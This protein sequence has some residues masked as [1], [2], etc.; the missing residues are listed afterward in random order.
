MSASTMTT[1][2]RSGKSA[3][4]AGWICLAGG[5]IG[6]AQ[7]LYLLFVTPVVGEDRFSYPFTA[8][9][10]TIAQL[11]FAIQHLML[12][13]G[14]VALARSDWARRSRLAVVGFWIAAAGFLLLTAM[15]LLALTAA[16]AATASPEA[17]LVNSLYG[18]PTIVCGIGLVL[19]GI[20]F[21]RSSG[22]AGWQ[23]WLPLALGIYVFVP[24]LPAVFAPYVWGRIAISVWMLLFVALGWLLI[25]PIRGA[26]A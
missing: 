13:I 17:D 9:G 1:T 22:M 26:T 14:V 25:R 8:T 7:G 10:F 2:T 20:G 11:T 5:V 12:V 24:L 3:P 21:A 4:T 16:D 6:F 19:G 23:R 15:E 18:I